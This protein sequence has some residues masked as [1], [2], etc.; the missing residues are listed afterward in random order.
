MQNSYFTHLSENTFIVPEKNRQR[1]GASLQTPTMLG[2]GFT[3]PTPTHGTFIK[4]DETPQYFPQVGAYNN[5]FI[6]QLN[7]ACIK[8][9]L[10]HDKQL[11]YAMKR[12]YAQWTM[13]LT[14]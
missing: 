5:E 2:G 12:L 13:N 14:C 4:V 1:L 3:K 7:L 8:P 6:A 10:N 9:A 11:C